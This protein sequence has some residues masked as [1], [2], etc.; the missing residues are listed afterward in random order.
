MADALQLMGDWDSARTVLDALAAHESV[1]DPD[2]YEN[3]GWNYSEQGAHPEAQAAFRY[4]VTLDAARVASWTGLIDATYYAEGAQ[5][6]WNV[7]QEATAAN[8]EASLY[9]VVGNLAWQ[10]GDTAGAE[11]AYLTAIELDPAYPWAY[12]SLAGVYDGGG[13]LDEALALLELGLERNP[14]DAWIHEALGQRRLD[15]GEV[16]V[17]LNHFRAASALE[18]TYGWFSLQ[19]AEAYYQFTGDASGSSVY[20]ERASAAQPDDADLLDSIGSVYES[21]GDCASAS[22]YYSRALELNPGIENSQAGL[23]RCGG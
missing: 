6:A 18:P 20:L 12:I 15:L 7:A 9:D 21:M 1:N 5:A 3:L 8:R 22:A 2:L 16:E 23:T 13:R 14:E 17:A 19:A 4:A 11:T 10:L